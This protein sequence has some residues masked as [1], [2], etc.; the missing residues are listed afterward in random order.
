MCVFPKSEPIFLVKTEL[1]VGASIFLRKENKRE[2]WGDL[3][4]KARLLI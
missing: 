3:E 2:K 1:Q 4:K